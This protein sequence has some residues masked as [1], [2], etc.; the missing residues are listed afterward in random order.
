MDKN[1]LL[2]GITLSGGEPLTQARTLAPLAR[3]VKERRLSVMLYSGYT[4]EEILQ[5]DGGRA[6][7]SYTDVL[8]D[9]K[10]ERQKRSLELP[11]RGSANQ[12]IIDVAQSLATGQPTAYRLE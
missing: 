9:G 8:V 1:P 3:A 5:N 6:L 7:L 10:F 4:F 11:F 2:D 12:R